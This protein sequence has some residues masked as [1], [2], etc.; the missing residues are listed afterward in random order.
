MLGS[1]GIFIASLWLALFDQLW[2]DHNE[3]TWGQ[4]RRRRLTQSTK[5]RSSSLFSPSLPVA[6][7]SRLGYES[8][9]LFLKSRPMPLSLKMVQITTGP[10]HLDHYQSHLTVHHNHIVRVLTKP[11]ANLFFFLPKKAST[12]NINLELIQAVF[13]YPDT[14]WY[15]MFFDQS[16]LMTSGT[17]LAN[18]SICWRLGTLWSSMGT[19]S[20]LPWKNDVSYV[21]SLHKLNIM[22]LREG[23]GEN[24]RKYDCSKTCLCAWRPG[25]QT[26]FELGSWIG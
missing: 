8:K 25:K 6:S 15:I 9:L 7:Q 11:F 13:Q 23:K 24:I 14:N 17:L 19:R 2:L 5:R 20:T 12:K 10:I 1:Q 4:L 22:Y 3:G 18:S 16:S 26:P 21:F